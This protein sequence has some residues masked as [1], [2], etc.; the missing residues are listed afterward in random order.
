MWNPGM[1]ALNGGC[2]PAYYCAMWFGWSLF[3]YP[4]K[5]SDIFHPFFVCLLFIGDCIVFIFLLICVWLD[6]LT[7]CSWFLWA[8]RESV[9]TLTKPIFPT[10][11]KLAR[12]SVLCGS[13][14]P[15][16]GEGCAWICCAIIRGMKRR[17]IIF[18]SVFGEGWL[19]SSVPVAWSWI[20]NPY[21]LT[22][23]DKHHL[24]SDESE[25]W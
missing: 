14:V 18:V 3:P 11:W 2:P 9:F 5:F 12:V 7:W 1:G 25:L 15:M 4:G 17:W 22:G 24:K 8:R 16:E 21:K 23:I 20:I 10:G 6:N 19:I 13:S